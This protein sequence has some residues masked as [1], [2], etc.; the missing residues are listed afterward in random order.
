VLRGQFVLRVVPPRDSGAPQARCKKV[1]ENKQEL[2]PNYHLDIVGTSARRAFNFLIAI[3]FFKLL[4]WDGLRNVVPRMR[5]PSR[6][7]PEPQR[8]SFNSD[9]DFLNYARKCREESAEWVKAN[10]ILV[11]L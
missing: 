11:N 8:L 2:Y 10:T 4:T 1:T 3:T 9:D 5:T 7:Q 6:N